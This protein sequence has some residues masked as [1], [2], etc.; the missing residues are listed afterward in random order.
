MQTKETFPNDGMDAMRAF[1]DSLIPSHLDMALRG[2]NARRAL[3]AFRPLMPAFARIILI[4][5]I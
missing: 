1:T 2:L 4:I 5:E 3:I